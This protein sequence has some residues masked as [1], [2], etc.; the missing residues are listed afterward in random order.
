MGFAASLQGHQILAA[1]KLEVRSIM[2]DTFFKW[3]TAF[4]HMILDVMVTQEQN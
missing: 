1:V 2:K 4:I 3:E